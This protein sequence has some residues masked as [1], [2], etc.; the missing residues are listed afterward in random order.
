GSPV[1]VMFVDLQLTRL[2]SLATDLNMFMFNSLE[3]SVRKPNVD[4]LLTAY[5]ASFSSVLEGCTQ[6]VPFTKEE[7]VKEYKHKHGFGL[8]FGCVDVPLQITKDADIPDMENIDADNW[9]KQ[10]LD[11]METN[12]LLKPRFVAMFDEMLEE[13]LFL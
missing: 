9:Q 6:V 10:M 13:G 8:L 1:E 2:A 7:L 4:Q 3:G 5:Y 12:P 11:S